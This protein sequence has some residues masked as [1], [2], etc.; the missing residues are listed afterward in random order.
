MTAIDADSSGTVSLEEWVEG[1]MNNIPLLVLLGLKV[2]LKKPNVS[3]S[4]E[5]PQEPSGPLL[6][7]SLAARPTLCR[8]HVTGCGNVV[9]SH[10]ISTP[11]ER[12]NVFHLC[13]LRFERLKHHSMSC[14]Q[15]HKTGGQITLVFW[16]LLNAGKAEAL[17]S[18]ACLLGRCGDLSPQTGL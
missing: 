1:G 4:I 14:C 11:S 16:V 8:P 10:A 7:P 15:K 2:L 5:C 18:S 12:C 9:C 13:N 6:P 17:C 3:V